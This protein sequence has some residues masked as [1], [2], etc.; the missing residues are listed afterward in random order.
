MEALSQ[1]CKRRKLS[2]LKMLE[3]YR[4]YLVF[5][6]SAAR[7]ADDTMQ[8]GGLTALITVENNQTVNLAEHFNQKLQAA[9]L[10]PIHELESTPS[11][12]E[13]A[14]I[15]PRDCQDPQCV[16]TAALYRALMISPQGKPI[17]QQQRTTAEW[18]EQLQNALAS[19]AKWKPS[20]N[21]GALDLFR[22]RSAA[23][24]N[25]LNLAPAGAARNLVTTSMLQFIAQHQVQKT[26]RLEWFLAVNSLIARTSIDPLGYRDVAAELRKSTDPVIA[27]YARLEA[28]APRPADRILGL[29]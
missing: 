10:Q 1:E 13:G 21:F 16:E 17:S 11:R 4:V 3:G 25:L 15:G 12:V 14:P 5:H 20:A 8:I 27:L 7:C 26:N 6:L 2:P 23:Y 22:E 19:L 18:A 24:S 28:V 29:L 9:P